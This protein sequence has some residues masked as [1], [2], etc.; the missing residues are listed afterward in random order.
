MIKSLK[1]KVKS[2]KLQKGALSLIVLIFGSV[3]ILIISGLV[4]WVDSNYKS[5]NRAVDQKTALMIA[6]A[7][8]E[9]YRWHLAHAPNDFQDGTG[10]PGP[11]V[12]DYK[13]KN[14]N[15][16]GQFSLE[17]TP[18]P[19]ESSVVSIKS[20]GKTT[21]D[22]NIQKIVRT[23]LGIP[24]VIKYA[25]LS[26]SNIRFEN[27]TR[28]IG[29]I[30]ANGGIRFDGTAEN[31]VTSSRTAYNDPDHSGPDEYGIHTHLSPVDP[32]PPGVL[33]ARG[34]V[35]Y[36]GREFP[37][38]AVDF[39]GLTES[40]AQIKTKAQSGG[41]YFG[42][43]GTK[44]YHIVLKNNDT[45]DIYKVKRMMKK[46]DRSC[47]NKLRQ[48]GW[49]I[50]SIRT[51]SGSEQLIGNYPVP[52]NGLIFVEDHVW[53]DGRINTARVTIASGRFSVSAK[54]YTN[55]I[56]D[57]DLLYT[58]YDGQDVIGLIAQGNVLAGMNS[59]NDLRV[60][61]AVVAQKGMVARY[62]Y[63]PPTSKVNC[64]PYNS[65]QSFL[66]YGMI[67]TNKGYGFAYTDGSGYQSRDIIY[68]SNL[69]YS[70]PPSFPLISGLYQQI[71]WDELK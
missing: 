9:Y 65:R 1:L 67:A 6:E 10:Q 35:F 61:A 41:K 17:I 7:G 39:N 52:A 43:S 11:Y 3:A 2:L 37:V 63:Q 29:P 28:V 34:D 60:D 44:G 33:P 71:S 42:R 46:P 14:G 54:N 62:Y 16:I 13:D 58:N 48:K 30:H 69:L 70:P 66:L 55:I 18:P 8:V 68:D 53:V 19:I 40:L 51:T 26:N 50:W 56:I 12:H 20:T 45:F 4:V 5:A 31:L 21:A 24:S 38:P 36:A 15:I 64:S 23:K 59:E 47:K 25:V 22:P 49:K 57:K 32:L 27:G